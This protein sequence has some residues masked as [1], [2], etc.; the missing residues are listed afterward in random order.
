MYCGNRANHDLKRTM[1]VIHDS[2]VTFF[3]QTKLNGNKSGKERTYPVVMDVTVV[4]V[5]GGMGVG[6]NVAAQA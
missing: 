1:D 3:F 4:A 5:V 6:V 2:T